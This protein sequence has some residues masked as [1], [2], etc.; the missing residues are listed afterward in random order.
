[1]WPQQKERGMPRSQVWSTGRGG[2]GSAPDAEPTTTR[3]SITIRARTNRRM[4]TNLFAHLAEEDAAAAA[5]P[6]GAPPEVLAGE[7]ADQ[8][9][10]LAARVGDRAPGF[11]Q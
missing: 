6:R 1:M 7:S 3:E 5:D 9:G 10:A 11:D 4:A 2:A 8:R